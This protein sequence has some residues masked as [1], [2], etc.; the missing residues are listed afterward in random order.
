MLT[1]RPAI[2]PIRTDFRIRFATDEQLNLLQ[3]GTL[4]ILENV[5]IQFP[6]EKALR[7][8]SDHGAHVD[9]N[10]QVVK[11]P[12]QL[13]MKALSTVPRYFK[14]GARHSSCDLQLQDGVTYFTSDGC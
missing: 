8:F 3:D 6:S 10:T 2:E 14:L 9:K 7:I 5:G 1:E 13:V 11:I 4:R 12:R